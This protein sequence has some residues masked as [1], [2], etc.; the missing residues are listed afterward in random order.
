[1]IKITDILWNEIK[2][3]IP[4]KNKIGRPQTDSR[5]V[6]NGI[7]F[8]VVTGIQWKHLPKEYGPH[9]TIH[10]RFRTWVKTGIFDKLF[11]LSIKKAIDK[12]GSA[13]CFLTDASSSKAPLALFGGKNATDRSKNGI[14]KSLVIDYKRIIFSVLIDS[15]NRHDSKFFMRHVDQIKKYVGLNPKV[16]MADSAYD[17]KKLR[18]YSTKHNLALLAATNTRRD[19]NKVKF[20]PKGRWRI[21]QIFG[22]QNWN[23]GIK[24]CWTKTAESFLAYCKFISAVHNFKLIGVFG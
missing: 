20:I 8:V 15:A 2:N 5:I 12:L 23:R 3:V 19:K 9:T 13:E 7:L 22:I 1:M 14:K 10:G 17:V 18:K 21:E 11:N 4:E 16:I 6:L 24:F